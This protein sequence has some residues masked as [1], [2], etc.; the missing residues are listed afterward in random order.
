MWHLICFNVII[1][2]FFLLDRYPCPH[3]MLIVGWWSSNPR[4]KSI[5]I[6]HTVPLICLMRY[7]ISPVFSYKP[8][9]SYRSVYSPSL[10]S[11]LYATSYASIRW[12]MLSWM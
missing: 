10:S 5:G 4:T 3:I 11:S 9:F 12:Y 7:V 1:Y 6:L 8:I 2:S